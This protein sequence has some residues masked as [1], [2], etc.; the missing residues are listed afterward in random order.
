MV[1]L[2]VETATR[3]GSVAV[4]IDGAIDARAGDPARTHGERLPQDLLDLLAAHGLGIDDVDLFAV[5]VGPGS[6]TGL[7]V[8]MATMQGF[9]LAKGKSVVPVSTLEAIV[10]S[11]WIE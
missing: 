10:D 5:V 8:G 9:A 3:A 7:R 4:A 2:A 6:F 1:I 11:W